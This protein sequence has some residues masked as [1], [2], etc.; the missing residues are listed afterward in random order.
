MMR[1]FNQPN[2]SDFASGR[3]SHSPQRGNKELQRNGITWNID[4]PTILKRI[5]LGICLFFAVGVSSANAEVIYSAPPD[6]TLS[7]GW[8]SSTLANNQ[9]DVQEFSLG[10]DATV[11]TISVYGMPSTFGSNAPQAFVLEFFAD[12]AG[13]PNATS[14]Y[15]TTTAAIAGVDTG[16][17]WFAWDIYKYT[18]NVPAQ[19][20][21]AGTTYWLGAKSTDTTVWIWSH[22]TTD[23]SGDLWFRTVDGAAWSQDTSVNVGARDNQ[24]FELEGELEDGTI[25][26]CIDPFDAPFDAPL[27][28]KAKK[29]GAIPVKLQLFDVDG[30]LVTDADL[31]ALPVVNVSFTP[32]NGDPSIDVTDVLLPVGQANDDNVFRFDS[33]E[34]KFIYNLSSKPYKASG[35]YT[36]T[37]VAG[38]SSYEIEGCSQTFTRQ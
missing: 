8:V 14:F 23:G 10:S 6:G 29:N 2:R 34:D 20:L 7:L 36:V 12:N 25:Y 11:T 37:A 32:S 30:F 28:L 26:A 4:S 3:Q 16:V 9:H 13:T 1:V 19:S 17:N 27:T 21:L 15:S 35:D 38:D 22:S 24:A 33:D 31:A 18:F 5:L